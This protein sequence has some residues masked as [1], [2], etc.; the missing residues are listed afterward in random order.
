MFVWKSFSKRLISGVTGK[1]EG[2]AWNN[3]WGNMHTRVYI[4]NWI[5]IL[6]MSNVDIA[7]NMQQNNMRI[8]LRLDNMLRQCIRDSVFVT[9]QINNDIRYQ[10]PVATPPRQRHRCSQRCRQSSRA[11]MC[12]RNTV[13]WQGLPRLQ[14]CAR[15]FSSCFRVPGAWRII[16][17]FQDRKIERE[18]SDI[19]SRHQNLPPKVMGWRTSYAVI[20]ITDGSRKRRY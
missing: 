2:I 18:T 10:A 13:A 16:M 17:R 20:L 7:D 19:Y 14:A 11:R 5:K 4:N 1:Q 3:Q 6:I 12:T 15:M 9:A 8:L